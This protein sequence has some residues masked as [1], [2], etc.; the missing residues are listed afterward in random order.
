MTRSGKLVTFALGLGVALGVFEAANAPLVALKSNET[1]LTEVS[2]VLLIYFILALAI[3][4]GCEV[5]MDLLLALKVVPPKSLQT[6]ASANL[7]RRLV[8]L[9]LCLLLAS[10]LSLAGLRFGEA[11]LELAA[12]PAPVTEGYFRVIDA[13]MT[14]LLLAGGS[15]GV[16]QVLR[17]LLGDKT[18]LPDSA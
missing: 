18:P 4:R 13:A 15:D 9:T 5:A 8:S 1:I 14:A 7:E 17:R 12:M 3:E 6:A 2:N 11:V 10:G 16:H